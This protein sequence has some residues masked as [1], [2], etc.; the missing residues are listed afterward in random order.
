[1]T[2]RRR[3][4]LVLLLVVGVVS[5]AAVVISQ[6]PT[7]LGLDLRGGVELVYE[8][9]PTPKVPEVTPQA[10]D[11]AIDVIRERTDSLGVAEAEIQR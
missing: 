3:N 7:R 5:A 11:D 1:M 10:V 4:A 6:W 2:S 9:R 8:A